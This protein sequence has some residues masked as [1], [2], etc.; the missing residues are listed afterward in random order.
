M[1]QLFAALD[2]EKSIGKRQRIIRA[3]LDSGELADLLPKGARIIPEIAV[4][5]HWSNDIFIV[6]EEYCNDTAAYGHGRERH[7][8]RPLYILSVVKLPDT[9]K[10]W[11]LI[12]EPN[13]KNPS[14]EDVAYLDHNNARVTMEYVPPLQ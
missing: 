1:N 12:I 5:A 2:R 10:H 4:R 11:L 13:S 8:H 7:E 14:V 6:G 9:D 3:F